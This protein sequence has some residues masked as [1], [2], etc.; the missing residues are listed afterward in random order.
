MRMQ[1]TT[2]IASALLMQNCWMTVGLRVGDYAT[3]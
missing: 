1:R 3:V 2:L